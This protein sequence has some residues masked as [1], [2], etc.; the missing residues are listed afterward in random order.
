M[1]AGPAATE[2]NKRTAFTTHV[3]PEIDVLLRVAHTLVPRPA[4]AEDLGHAEH[5]RKPGVSPS[6]SVL[7]LQP[8]G[9]A[10]RS[11]ARRGPWRPLCGSQIRQEGG[12]A[13]KSLSAAGYRLGVLACRKM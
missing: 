11:T 7:R 13:T 10:S 9:V 1:S 6:H 3:V 5:V 8:A 4:D 12:V 2:D